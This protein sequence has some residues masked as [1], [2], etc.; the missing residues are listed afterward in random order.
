LHSFVKAHDVQSGFS[1][2]AWGS[3]AAMDSFLND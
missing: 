3:K 1:A 2:A